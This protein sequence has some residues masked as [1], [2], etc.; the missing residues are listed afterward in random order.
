MP[1]RVF[2]KNI[3]YNPYFTKMVLRELKHRVLQSNEKEEKMFIYES[4]RSCLKCDEVFTD[5]IDM[6]IHIKNNHI[7]QIQCPSCN[8]SYNIKK[9]SP[10]P[11][12]HLSQWH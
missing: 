12:E 5:S 9:V 7:R 11:Q 6:L 8:K 4:P 2:I 1:A 10:C 3:T